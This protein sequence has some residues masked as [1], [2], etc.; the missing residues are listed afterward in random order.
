LP[1]TTAV[2]TTVWFARGSGDFGSS[3]MY[4]RRELAEGDLSSPAATPGG[5]GGL[6]DPTTFP[7]QSKTHTFSR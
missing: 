5:V 1:A 7:F 3:R 2:T 6:A 4:T